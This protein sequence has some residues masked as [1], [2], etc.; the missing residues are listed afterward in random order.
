[1]TIDDVGNVAAFLLSD[2]AAGVTGEITYVDGGFSRVAG[3][4][5][6]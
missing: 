4:M 1:V 5:E 2:L 6:G 3:G